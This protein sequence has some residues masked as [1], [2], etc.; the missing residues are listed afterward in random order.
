LGVLIGGIGWENFSESDWDVMS[1]RHDL[2]AVDA[3]FKGMIAVLEIDPQRLVTETVLVL[4]DIKR[5]TFY[6][7]DA[8]EVALQIKENIE[9][10]SQGLAWALEQIEKLLEEQERDSGS[11]F[12]KIPQVPIK[13]RWERAREVDLSP[14]DLVRA[15]DH[16]SEIIV[17][18][19]ALLLANGAGGNEVAPV[20][21]LRIFKSKLIELFDSP[22]TEV[23]ESMVRALASA[24]W[25]DREEAIILAQKALQDDDL[26]VRD[27]AVETL[28]IL[29]RQ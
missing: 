14:K 26:A 19:A 23:R 21:S 18:S 2:R 15:L 3:V 16:P 27:Q 17:R 24:D 25:L 22:Y 20:E 7:L 28:R 13:F 10:K 4:E 12:G 8:I 5:I 1:H 11:L 6:D 29:E 9:N